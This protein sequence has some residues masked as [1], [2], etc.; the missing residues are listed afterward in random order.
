M[1]VY[2]AGA[3]AGLTEK[4]A[5]DWRRYVA[6]ELSKHMV[7]GVSPLRCE[8]LVGERYEVVY[9]DPRFG[10]GR[11][12]A[13]KN[14]FDTRNCDFA[15][16]YLPKPPPGGRLS[17]GSIIELAWAHA[18]NKPT[19]L[20]TDD[21]V[22]WDHPLTDACASWKLRTLDEAIEVIVGVSGAYTGGKN[23]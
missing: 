11:A 8:P 5:K 16:V 21:P 12:I 13:A 19:I 20:V 2:L 18:F 1:R 22:I 14:E 17:I 4:E 15:L 10:S 9:D 23:V 3:I 7:T 6:N